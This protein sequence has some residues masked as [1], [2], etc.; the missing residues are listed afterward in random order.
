MSGCPI[1]SPQFG[2]RV[3][4][5]SVKSQLLPPRHCLNLVSAARRTP[6]YPELMFQITSGRLRVV[7]VVVFVFISLWAH[8]QEASTNIAPTGSLVIEDL[9]KG[10]VALHGPWQFHSGDDPAW[11]APAFDDSGWEPL[12]ADSPWG[13]Q[14]HVRYTGFA[15]Y[16]CSIAID[17]SRSV[18]PQLSLLVPRIDDAYEVYWNGSLVGGS[19]RLQPRPVWLTVQ[20]AQTFPLGQAQRGV[21]A[22]RVWKAPLL[23][24]DSGAQGGFESA[25][26]IGSPEAVANAKAALD[27]RW[28][29][30]RQLL[31]GENLI[32]T[33]V[34]LLSFLLWWRNSSRW[35]LFWVMGFALIPPINLLLLSAHLPLPYTLAMGAAQPLS[36]IRDISLWFVLLWLLQLHEN[37]PMTRL[38]RVLAII[39]FANTAFDGVLVAIS[40]NH[41]WIGWCRIA[42]AASAILYTPIEAFPL[43]LIGY[44]FFKRKHL[45]RAPWLVAILAFLDEMIVV[46]RNAV[47][48]GRQ[49][50]GWTFDTR[51][52]APLF[53]VGGS[54][55]SLYTLTGALL[56]IA[57]VY[58]V[59]KSIREDQLR[60]AALEREKVELMHAREQMRHYAEHDGLT[61]LWN[62]RII[63]E[64]LRGELDRA[65]REG[66]PLSVVLADVDHFKKVNDSFGHLA[67]DQ[68]LKE[69]SA[70]IMHSVRSYDW[71]GR[72]GGEEFLIILPGSGYESALTRAE[73]LRLAVQSARID[74]G[75]SPL[76]VT[77]SFGVA[78]GFASD[79]EAEAVI[80][81]VDAALYRAKNSGR[82]CVIAAGMEM[83]LCES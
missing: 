59:Y 4:S 33:L 71:V 37:R 58:A 69:I 46:V 35:L 42:D 12:S 14:G 6:A 16:R 18:P 61:G 80:Q 72:Y 10:A 38:I 24:D 8:A 83:S 44:A 15:W 9:G 34:A 13:E 54:A 51:I 82:N 52:D 66:T 3:G 77:A 67:G 26:V 63:V 70:I 81:T 36:S 17:P 47:K 31:F 11:A 75:S 45:D 65:R 57:I 25:P 56:L 55:I 19:G 68:V 49:F 79:C 2:E 64:R 62:H 41:R 7:P 76:H 43:F 1:L 48:Q 28:L 60:Q 73:Q 5:T 40:W 29:E 50:T 53:T 39:G 78:S 30:S 27:Y 23:S 32:Y 74:N 22:I 20:A 21:L